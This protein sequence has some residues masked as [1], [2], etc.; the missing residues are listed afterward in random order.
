MGHITEKASMAHGERQSARQKAA[1]QPVSFAATF[2]LFQPAS[3]ASSGVVR[4]TAV[5]FLPPWGFEELCTHK[6]FRVM[7]E[8]FAT[9]GI[10]SLRFDYPGTGDALDDDAGT[11]TLDVWY[12]TI[13]AAFDLLREKTGGI[14][15]MLVGHGLGASMGLEMAERLDGLCGL[16]AMAPV[17]SGRGY[18]REL[19]LW[20]RMID[21]G[22]SLPEHLRLR[23]VASIAGLIM[24]DG[25]SNALK[26][27]DFST[28]HPHRTIPYLFVNRPDRPADK[29]LADLMA[30]KGARVEQSDYIGFEAMI[31]NPSMARLPLETMEHLVSWVVRRAAALGHPPHLV[32]NTEISETAQ[33]ETRDFRETAMRFGRGQRLYGILCEP[34]GPRRGASVL[35]ASTAYDRQSGW[36]RSGVGMARRLARA[37]IASFRFDPA[38]VG[39]SPPV[40]GFPEQVLYAETQYDDV[41]AAL[42]VLEQRDLL[43]VIGVGRCSGGYLTFSSMIKDHRLVGAC[44]AN[45]F[46][47]YWDPKRDVDGALRVVPRS[48]DTYKQLMVRGD[49]FRRVLRGDVD[50]KNAARNFLSVGWGRFISRTGLGNIISARAR[51]N[52][53][54]VISAFKRLAKRKAKLVLLYSEDD[55][56]LEHVYQHFGPDGHRLK[57]YDN[58]EVQI[59]PETDHNFSPEA[60]QQHYFKEIRDLALSI[61]S[62]AIRLADYPKTEVA[63]QPAVSLK[64]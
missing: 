2:G 29:A 1:A 7:A 36:G 54:Q 50:I 4:N 46:A 25:V 55:V 21:E 37:G 10:A 6:L 51:L 45:P 12:D 8:E 39:D 26:K 5:L 32:S 9:D 41:E 60:A 22:L 3:G 14:P 40:P 35:L 34:M 61:G 18:L 53:A 15:I 38:N 52:H 44:L 59:V 33:L 64:T 62:P 23:D 19:Q 49:T 58:V 31:A 11:I 16:V 48:L 63:G 27:K 17:G 42:N 57:R 43:P 47:F 20:A 13:S 56:G 30:T 24:P 28:A